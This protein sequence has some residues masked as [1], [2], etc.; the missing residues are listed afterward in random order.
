MSGNVSLKVFVIPE[1]N[2]LKMYRMRVI[3]VILPN[4]RKRDLKASFFVAFDLVFSQNPMVEI[5][6]TPKIPEVQNS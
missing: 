2:V 3:F 6:R 1:S 4:I 5:V